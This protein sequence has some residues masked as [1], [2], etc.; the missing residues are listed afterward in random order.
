MD[1]AFVLLW[2]VEA[3]S[4]N[5][6]WLLQKQWDKDRIIAFVVSV[7]VCLLANF[8]LFAI[9]EWPLLVPYAGAAL[10]GI[11]VARGANILH[12]IAKLTNLKANIK[13]SQ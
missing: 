2:M 1:K 3:I 8:D 7:L 10:T 6:K 11:A 13:A 12:D 9:I 4:E 5:I